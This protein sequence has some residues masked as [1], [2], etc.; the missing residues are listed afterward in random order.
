MMLE[1]LKFALVAYAP[2]PACINTIVSTSPSTGALLQTTGSLGI[3]FRSWLHTKHSPRCSRTGIPCCCKGLLGVI[4][5]KRFSLRSAGKN[6]RSAL[7]SSST[8][9]ARIPHCF[10]IQGDQ[11]YVEL[12]WLYL[13]RCSPGVSLV[14][15]GIAKSLLFMHE[16]H[17]PHAEVAQTINAIRH[18][19]TAFDPT[20]RKDENPAKNIYTQERKQQASGIT[21]KKTKGT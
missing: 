5:A 2:R 16:N 4:S 10:L 12:D 8:K 15:A 6:T 3:P 13:L 7:R 19:I 1:Y 9:L 11:C 18:V 20:D 21:T 14:Y 17:S